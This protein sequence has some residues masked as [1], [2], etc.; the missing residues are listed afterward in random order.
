MSIFNRFNPLKVR[1][2]IETPV[3]VSIINKGMVTDIDPAD[4]DPAALT[5]AFNVVIRN[6]KIVRRA[7]STDLTVAVPSSG[8][9]VTKL[10]YVKKNNGDQFTFRLTPTSLYV[11]DETSGWQFYTPDAPLV[12]AVNDRFE[13]AIVDDH[14]VFSNNGANKIQ[15]ID[16]DTKTFGDLGNAPPYR[17]ICGMSNRLVGANLR[18]DDETEIGWSGDRNITVFDRTG[19]TDISSGFTSLVHTPSDRGDFIRGVFNLTTKLIIPRERSMWLG[20]QQGIATFP[21]FFFPAIPNVGCDCPYSAVVTASGLAWMDKRTKGVYHW[22]GEPGATPDSI[23]IGLSVR[24]KIF[25]AINDPASVFSSYNPIEDEYYICVPIVGSTDVNIF[26]HNFRLRTWTWGKINSL[27]AMDFVR[28]SLGVLV[29][30]ELQ[31]LV[32]DL[33][34]IVEDLI[35]EDNATDKMLVGGSSGLVAYEDEDSDYD[36]V[37]VTPTFTDSKFASKVFTLDKSDSYFSMLVIEYVANKVG[38]FTVQYNITDTTDEAEWKTFKSLSNGPLGKPQVLKI[39]KL[40]RCRRFAWR[41]VSNCRSFN[42]LRYET[43]IQ[44][45]GEFQLNR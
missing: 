7:G 26:I 36:R 23:N 31:G 43:Y 39:K 22:N 4:L 38:N 34:D 10:A 15:E 14:I 11:Y 45:A 12:G 28:L 42:V 37:A 3:A 8:D 19:L 17:Y 6:D 9:E 30:E 27:T 24:S 33:T 13:V 32:E 1:G 44:R 29:V 5:E 35:Q 20:T 21:F 25:A 2:T 18:A 40:V 41:V 16:P